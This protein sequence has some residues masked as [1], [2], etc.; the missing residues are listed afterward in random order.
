MAARDGGQAGFTLVEVLVALAVTAAVITAIGLLMGSNARAT[1]ALERRA[2]LMAAAQAVEAGI[3]PRA[4][5]RDGRIEGAVAGHA[6]HM[7]V[8]PMDVGAIPDDAS[9]LPRHVRIRV[10]GPGGDAVEIET[11]RLVP[12]GAAD[13]AE[14]DVAD[15]A[16][17]SP[18]DGAQ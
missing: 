17:P 10:T 1:R 9:W 11:V 4:R 14:G 12:T 5:L 16:T 13:T 6:W 2:A 15:D 8:S 7:D 18:A 3:P